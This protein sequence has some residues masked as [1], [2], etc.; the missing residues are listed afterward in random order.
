MTTT[1]TNTEKYASTF[2]LLES[3]DAL[4]L[5]DGGKIFIVDASFTNLTK[6]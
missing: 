2:L 4:L 6:N 5:E 1:F 3:G